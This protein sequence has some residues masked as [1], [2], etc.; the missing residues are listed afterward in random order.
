[1]QGMAKV[2]I[3]NSQGLS[4]NFHFQNEYSLKQGW[5]KG[6]VFLKPPPLESKFLENPYS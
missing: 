3:C 2:Y 4:W 6:G 5:L 1:M